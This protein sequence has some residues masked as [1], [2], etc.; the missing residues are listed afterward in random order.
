MC[1]RHIHSIQVQF[2]C[3]ECDFELHADHNASINIARSEEFVQGTSNELVS[4]CYVD[5]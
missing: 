2:K 5:N 3:V 4:F 1:I